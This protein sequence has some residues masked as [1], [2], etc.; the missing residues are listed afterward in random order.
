M[1]RYIP[2]ILLL[3]LMLSLSCKKIEHKLLLKGIFTLEAVYVSGSEENFMNFALPNYNNPEGCCKYIIDFQDDGDMFGFYYV[4]DELN[5]VVKGEWEQK[6]YHVLYLNL[7]KYVNGIYDV[8][9]DGKKEFTL[10]TEE[11]TALIGGTAN[12]TPMVLKITRE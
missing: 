6:D 1:R 2:A 11:N 5:Y 10:S 3:A 4:D 12:V 9:K 7:D 8:E